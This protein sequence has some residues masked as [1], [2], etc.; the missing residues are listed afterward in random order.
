M[1]FLLQ[2]GPAKY[3]ATQLEL[4]YNGYKKYA[5]EML[6]VFEE[7]MRKRWEEAISSINKAIEEAR[8]K[9]PIA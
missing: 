6:K 8:K 1:D 3:T 5:E 7:H 4:F 9:V 2:E